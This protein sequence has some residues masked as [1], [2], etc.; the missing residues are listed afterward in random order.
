VELFQN[1]HGNILILVLMS[2]ISGIFGIQDAPEML[3]RDSVCENTLVGCFPDLI[4]VCKILTEVE[5]EVNLTRGSETIDLLS[6][7]LWKT[8]R[9]VNVLCGVAIPFSRRF[10]SWVHIP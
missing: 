3:D 7:S 6:W 5:E 9:P 4:S 10:S 8:P 1:V 2:D